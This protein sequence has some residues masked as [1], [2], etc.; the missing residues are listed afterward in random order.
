MT[1]DELLTVIAGA[2]DFDRAGVEKWRTE[3]LIIGRAILQAA[4]RD[5]PSA[6]AVDANRYRDIRA[7]SIG[8]TVFP[9]NAE[10]DAYIDETIASAPKGDG[11]D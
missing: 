3:A 7:I 10:F 5:A 1:D 9:S 6:D 8:E 4:T 11:N 2:C